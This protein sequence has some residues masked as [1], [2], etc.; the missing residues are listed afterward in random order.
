MRQEWNGEKK[1]GINSTS[2]HNLSRFKITGRQLAHATE[3]MPVNYFTIEHLFD[4]LPK[5]AMAGTFLDIGCGKGRAMCVAA[6]YGFQHV[7]GIDFAKE[8]ID[9]AEKNLLLTK[10]RY[11]SLSYHLAWDDVS[12]LEIGKQVQTIFLFNPFDEV[13]IKTVLQKIDASLKAYPRELYVLYASP[14]H[15]EFFFAAGY[16]VLFRVKKYRFLEGIILS[17][18]K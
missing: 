14:R 18:K 7:A 2:F 6:A 8:M 16:D 5:Q 13:L 10:Q 4:H 3:Y 12:T 1:Y 11:S 9:A 15:E 17:K